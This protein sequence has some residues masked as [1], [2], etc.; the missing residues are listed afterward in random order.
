METVKEQ[1]VHNTSIVCLPYYFNL[2]LKCNVTSFEPNT[3]YST[4]FSPDP[5]TI[6]S[7]SI[8][9]HFK[10]SDHTSLAKPNHNLQAIIITLIWIGLS[11]YFSF[12]VE[13]GLKELG[14][15]I[16]VNLRIGSMCWTLE[17]KGF[18]V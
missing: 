4:V 9:F 8:K 15:N 11:V 2:A 16:F 14:L 10:S 7:S 3:P 18:G 17:E 5:P 13:L 6:S 1:Y 12:A